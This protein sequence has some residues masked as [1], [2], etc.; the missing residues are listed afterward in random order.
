MYDWM[1]I[2]IPFNG[3]KIIKIPQPKNHKY[4]SV[5]ELT[6]Q[7]VP[8]AILYYKNKDRKPYQ[9]LTVGFD[10]FRLDS[11]GNYEETEVERKMAFHKSK[12]K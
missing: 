8:E 4:K 6:N 1:Q 12:K 5:P 9:L 11:N 2:F 10:R 7:N 3:D